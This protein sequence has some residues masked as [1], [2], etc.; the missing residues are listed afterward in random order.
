M[1]QLKVTVASKRHAVSSC[2]PLLIL[3]PYPATLPLPSPANPPV[4]PTCHTSVSG[5]R[6][7]FPDRLLMW[8]S[9]LTPSTSSMEMYR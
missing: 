1:L 8:S 7:P 6:L 4:P 5:M 2:L 3:L 9:R